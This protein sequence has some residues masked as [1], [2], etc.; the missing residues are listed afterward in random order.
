[1]KES[2]DYKKFFDELPNQKKIGVDDSP[3]WHFPFY[4]LF[5]IAWK[6][7]LI[8]PFVIGMTYLGEGWGVFFGLS[9][10]IVS[11]SIYYCFFEKK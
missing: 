1:M 2:F 10:F 9:C 4:L 7:T 8:V 5:W 3:L 6:L 11:G